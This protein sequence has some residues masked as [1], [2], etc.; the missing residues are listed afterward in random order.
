[1]TMSGKE[2]RKRSKSEAVEYNMRLS[3]AMLH[4]YSRNRF[5]YHGHSKDAFRYGHMTSC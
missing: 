5:T 1:M 3:K 2:K 4:P